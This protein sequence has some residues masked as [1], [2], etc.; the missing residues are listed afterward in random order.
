MRD[1]GNSSSH[2]GYRAAPSNPNLAAIPL[3]VSV[4]DK[5]IT[6]APT[7]PAELDQ[8]LRAEST[9]TGATACSPI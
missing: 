7:G 3:D 8:R 1:N 5:Y 4:V 9:E 6:A 2:F